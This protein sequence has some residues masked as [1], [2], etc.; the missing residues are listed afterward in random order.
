MR[1]RRHVG[2]FPAKENALGTETGRY[3]DASEDGKHARRARRVGRA[4]LAFRT[5]GHGVF[6][7]GAYRPAEPRI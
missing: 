1:L 5:L 6:S 7:I 3:R 2:C 4:V